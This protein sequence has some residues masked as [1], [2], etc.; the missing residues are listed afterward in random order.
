MGGSGRDGSVFACCPGR[1]AAGGRDRGGALYSCRPGR[2]AAGGGTPL[3][4]Y[5]APCSSSCAAAR[6]AGALPPAPSPPAA[7]RPSVVG[8]CGFPFPPGTS[9]RG[10]EVAAWAS[11]VRTKAASPRPSRRTARPAGSGPRWRPLPA[12]RRIAVIDP[13]RRKNSADEAPPEPAGSTTPGGT[14]GRQRHRKDSDEQGHQP[15]GPG[16]PISYQK[17]EQGQR[18]RDGEDKKSESGQPGLPPEGFRHAF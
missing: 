6:G 1:G 2:G 5:P 17:G 15:R 16:P 4:G 8:G 7:P 13:A 14:E 10:G 18:R 9:V 11:E 3:G 12:R